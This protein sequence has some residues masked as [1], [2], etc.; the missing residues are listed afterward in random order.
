[1]KIAILTEYYPSDESPG[2]GVYVHIRAA[3]YRKLGHEARVFVVRPGAQVSLERDGVPA[4][5]ADAETARTEIERFR[6][7]VLAL[8]TPHPSAPH[9]RLA[10]RLN[11]PRVL[12]IHGYEAMLTAFHG[13]HRGLDRLLSIAYDLPKLWRLR[14]TIARAT[15]VVYVSRWIQRAAERGTGFRHRRAR[16]VPNPVDTERF[17]PFA[18]AAAA[19][20][21]RGLVL[22]PLNAAHGAD[23]AVRALAGLSGIE[24]AI[25]GQG[26][27]ADRIRD[28]TERLRAPVTIEERPVPHD[29]M[30]GLLNRYDFFISPE[31]KTPTQGVAMCEAMACGLPVIA[32]RA[33]G[34]PEYVRDG[35]DG[36][37]VRRD[38]PA[39]L[40]HSVRLL[41]DDPDRL[42]EMGRSAR[43]YVVAKCSASK[44]IPAELAVLQEA[45]HGERSPRADSHLAPPDVSMP[46]H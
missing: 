35:T 27:D 1:M 31:R 44:V 33:G 22:R 11:V 10:E 9:T 6:P 20:R 15:A 43:E 8:H 39:A 28:L 24:V 36:Y 42:R 25:V 5:A 32:V 13:Y 29:E 17:R 45:S 4:L 23:L 26:P 18:E 40:R 16:V 3:S 7:A 34:V 2:S 37:L 19:E 38:D 30:P 41:A 14:S 46:G 21:P 12:W